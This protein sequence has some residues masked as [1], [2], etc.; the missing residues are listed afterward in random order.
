MRNAIFVLVIA[1]AAAGCASS[2]PHNAKA[3]APD[4]EVLELVGPADLGYTYGLADLRFEVRVANHA[5][6]PITLRRFDLSTV[7]G[8]GAYTLRRDSYTFNETIPANGTGTVTLWAHAFLLGRTASEMEPTTV[9]GIA[10]FDSPSGGVRKI[11]LQRF[12]PY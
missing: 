6:E 1:L 7:S 3:P 10:I 4:V 11:F 9:R 2:D 12:D 8:G 5:A